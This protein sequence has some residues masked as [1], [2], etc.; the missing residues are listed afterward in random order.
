[1]GL[2]WQGPCQGR[3]ELWR[4]GYSPAVA[5]QVGAASPRAHVESWALRK[6]EDCSGL[7]GTDRAGR[8]LISFVL[9]SLIWD[10][11]LPRCRIS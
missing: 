5:L 7:A 10:K 4:A 8:V 11:N 1:M 3:A 6:V 9:S 2:V